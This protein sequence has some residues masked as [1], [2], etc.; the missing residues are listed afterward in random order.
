[1]MSVPKTHWFGR[2]RHKTEACSL[3]ERQRS[4]I[5]CGVRAGLKAKEIAYETFLPTAVVK[6]IIN[7]RLHTDPDVGTYEEITDQSMSSCSRM[8]YG[9]IDLMS[10]SIFDTKFSILRENCFN[11]EVCI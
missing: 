4:S 9:E 5:Y 2:F 11:A 3:N 10:N 1:M 6:T 7:Q 8:A